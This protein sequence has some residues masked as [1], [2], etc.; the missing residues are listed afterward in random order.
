MKKVFKDNKIHVSYEAKMPWEHEF[1][2]IDR[3]LEEIKTKARS[4]Y[5]CFLYNRQWNRY[6]CS[7][8]K[9]INPFAPGDFAENRVLKLVEW[10]SG[11][12]HAIK[13]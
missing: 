5:K 6:Y 2:E 7:Y 3:V 8:Y 9:G 10:F 11:H 1:D 4:E 13:S 12:C